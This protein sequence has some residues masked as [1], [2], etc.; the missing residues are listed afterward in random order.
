MDYSDLN[1]DF[2]SLHE[3]VQIL[4]DISEQIL[5]AFKYN[6]GLLIS[7]DNWIHY[8]NNAKRKRIR[9]KYSKKIM[10]LSY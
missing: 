5:T 3:A 6:F 10:R 1:I 9:Q 8:E 7:P 2:D 4:V